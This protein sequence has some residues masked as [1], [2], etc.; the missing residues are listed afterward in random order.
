M[1]SI[2]MGCFEGTSLAT[3]RAPRPGAG[4]E[5]PALSLCTVVNEKALIPKNVDLRRGRGERKDAAD[6][7]TEF[8]GRLG[9]HD[10]MYPSTLCFHELSCGG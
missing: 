7:S 3:E 8:Q 5:R 6:G 1:S 9:T 4:T 10:N 2:G